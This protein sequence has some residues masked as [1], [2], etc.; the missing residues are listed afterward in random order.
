MVQ[1]EI[2]LKYLKVWGCRAIVRIPGQ[3][4]KKLG[5]RGLEYIFI[6][7]ANKEKPIGSIL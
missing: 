2:K 4:R 7:Y 6:G 1:K 3:K 5:E